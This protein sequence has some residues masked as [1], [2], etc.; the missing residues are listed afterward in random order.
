MPP[1]IHGH[2]LDDLP[3]RYAFLLFGASIGGFYLSFAVSPFS[4]LF[5]LEFMTIS[6]IASILLFVNT[7]PT[8]AE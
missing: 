3:E 2:Q 6:A 8:G 5:A 1:T 7:V 4:T